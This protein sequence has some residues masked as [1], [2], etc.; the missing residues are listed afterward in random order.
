MNHEV[1]WSFDLPKIDQLQKLLA[2]V[3][4]CPLKHLLFKSCSLT[5]YHTIL[6]F[7][8]KKPFENIVGK[9][10]NAG[11]QHFLLFRRCLLPNQ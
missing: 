5:L 8:K 3:R 9:G 11:K 2:K 6:T 7:S 10:E 4:L 1:E